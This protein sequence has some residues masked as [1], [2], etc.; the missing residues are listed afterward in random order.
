MVGFFMLK[1]PNYSRRSAMKITSEQLKNIIKEE[2]TDLDKK[3]G[4]ERRSD[5]VNSA[6]DF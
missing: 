5:I 3:Y 1:Q 6:D 2:L 4:D